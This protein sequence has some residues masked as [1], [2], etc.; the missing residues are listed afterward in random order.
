M[1]HENSID[2]LA[3]KLRQDIVARYGVMLNFGMMRTVLGYTS[4]GALRQA[5]TR[6]T[7]PVPI[8]KI[9]HR[10]GKFALA[11]DVASWL[12]ASRMAAAKETL[13]K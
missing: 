4:D 3:E 12:A 5:L 11:I 13:D 2:V 10:R 1:I 9:P 7:V 6:G 8:F